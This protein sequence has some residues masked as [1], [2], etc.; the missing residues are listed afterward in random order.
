[1]WWYGARQ[2]TVMQCDWRNADRTDA[3]IYLQRYTHDITIAC[4]GEQESWL[5]RR[6]VMWMMMCEW[7]CYRWRSDLNKHTAGGMCST[8]SIEYPFAS[9]FQGWVCFDMPF[10]RCNFIIPLVTELRAN[11]ETGLRGVSNTCVM[12]KNGCLPYN[13]WWCT[14]R[15]VQRVVE[16][17][18][19]GV[20]EKSFLLCE[21]FPCNPAE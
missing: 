19:T 3:Q 10:S 9:P 1:M 12:Q 11:I 16:H 7:W 13:V 4:C 2:Y 5:H 6:Y 8:W 20:C 21:P 18:H 15:V 17:E 14:H